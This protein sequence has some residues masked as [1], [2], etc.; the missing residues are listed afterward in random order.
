MANV[1]L[2]C[3]SDKQ[4]TSSRNE[5]VI[6]FLSVKYKKYKLHKKMQLYFILSTRA[7]AVLSELFCNE[8]YV[9]E[10]TA[11]PQELHRP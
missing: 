11:L 9:D 1:H 8:E 6:L 5:F 2:L 4:S 3:T 10:F 7:Q